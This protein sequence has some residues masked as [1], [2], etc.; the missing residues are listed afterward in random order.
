MN[1]DGT[2][3]KVLLLII[4]AGG[5]V[6]TYLPPRL[7]AFKCFVEEKASQKHFAF[8]LRVSLV[9]AACLFLIAGLALSLKIDVSTLYTCQGNGCVDDNAVGYVFEVYCSFMYFSRG[10]YIFRAISLVG[11]A[12]FFLCWA[13]CLKKGISEKWLLLIGICTSVSLALIYVVDFL[14]LRLSNVAGQSQQTLVSWAYSGQGNI[15]IGLSVI[16]FGFYLYFA[17]KNKKRQDLLATA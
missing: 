16:F 14:P 3:A 1:T 11:V 9:G 15:L 2:I 17:L 12:L 6:L 8:F 13:F 4:L 7:A 10:L 5:V